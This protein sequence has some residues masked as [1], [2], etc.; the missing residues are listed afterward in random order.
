M[1]RKPKIAVIGAKGFPA[2]GGAA[3]SNEAIFTRLKDN[4]DITVYAISSHTSETNYQGI[5]QII[6]K[7]HKNKKISVLLYYI[8]ALVHAL[9]R[10]KFNVVH[11]N[12]VSAGF[13]IPLLRIKYI[14]TLT[15]HGNPFTKN[16]NKWSKP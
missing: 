14:T 5:K 13:I 3:R 10:G 6:F 11:V 12:H 4:Y 1:K 2:W 7:A 15:V 8:K 9:L 16:D